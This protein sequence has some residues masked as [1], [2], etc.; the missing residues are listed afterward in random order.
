MPKRRK[1]ERQLEREN[2]WK[3]HLE[4]QAGS[5]LSQRAYCIQEGLSIRG[6]S[7]WGTKFRNRKG[8]TPKVAAKSTGK[9]VFLP[10]RVKSAVLSEQNAVSNRSGSHLAEAAAMRKF[11]W[12]IEIAFPNGLMVRF[13]NDTSMESLAE[14]LGVITRLPC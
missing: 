11:G 7:Y 1:N 8:A 10:V 13:P 3:Q 4:K 14:V 5:G 9:G 2:F 12:Q 6:L